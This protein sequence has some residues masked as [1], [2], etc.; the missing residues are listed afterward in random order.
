MQLEFEIGNNK[1]YKVNSI[2]NNIVYT[3]KLVIKQLLE[4]YYLFL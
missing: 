4:L 2:G 1:K 3:K